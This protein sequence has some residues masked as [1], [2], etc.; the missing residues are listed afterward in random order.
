MMTFNAFSEQAAFLNYIRHRRNRQEIYRTH[1]KG[2]MIKISKGMV[3]S[4][5]VLP[6]MLFC[7]TITFVFFEQ[8][9][10]IVRVIKTE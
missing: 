9:A 4:R 10:Y 7:N 2:V 8:C 3:S 6:F 1:I 5:Y